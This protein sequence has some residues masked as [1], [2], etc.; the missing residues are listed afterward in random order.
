MGQDN[1]KLPSLK[2]VDEEITGLFRMLA[3]PMV[4]GYQDVASILQKPWPA[5][6]EPEPELI[7]RP[8]DRNKQQQDAPPP[9]GRT[10]FRRLPGKY[11]QLNGPHSLSSPALSHT[12]MHLR[13]HHLALLN[14]MKSF[15][16]WKGE[17][18]TGRHVSKIEQKYSINLDFP[19]TLAEANNY[20]VASSMDGL[21]SA[22]LRVYVARIRAL[23]AR[24]GLEP[25]FGMWQVTNLLK[26]VAHL[27]NR[28]SSKERLS[29][30]PEL[31]K[32][33][34]NCIELSQ[35]GECW[36]S[37]IWMLFTWFWI[38]AFRSDD[39]LPS[40]P[41][42]FCP[43]TDLLKRNVSSRTDHL[44]GGKTVTYL[45]IFIPSPKHK[46]GS[47]GMTVELLPSGNWFCPVEAY[48]RYSK[49]TQD[50]GDEMPL[51]HLDG[52]LYTAKMFNKDLKN[53]FKGKMGPGEQISS[54]SF[55]SGVVSAL[56]RTGASEELLKSQTDHSSSAYRAYLKL[57]RAARLSQQ[58][59]VISTLEDLAEKN[60]GE[61]NLVV[62]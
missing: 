38:G 14:S 34:K 19:W 31:M 36:K 8:V 5:Y 24:Y 25:E 35:K 12:P 20:I 18:S 16:T 32:Y 53:I 11:S 37:L 61:D 13:S 59:E 56:A 3:M 42:A 23:H 1:P 22:S 6:V 21:S 28:D 2:K 43:E 48:S 30:T 17:S 41:T 51:A 45:K 52:A 29:V 57:G 46:K 39:L 49:A 60:F 47:G 55:R 33:A 54:H 26:G 7:W 62:N 4:R 27:E 10:N 9:Q 15:N 50:W 58:L 40:S 44:G